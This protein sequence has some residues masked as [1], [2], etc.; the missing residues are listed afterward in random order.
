MVPED[1]FSA[2]VTNSCYC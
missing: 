1:I 2:N